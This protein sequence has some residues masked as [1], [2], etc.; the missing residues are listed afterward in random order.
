MSKVSV[1]MPAFNAGR[2]I[3]QAIESVLAQTYPHYEIVVVDDGSTDNTAEVTRPYLGQVRYIRQANSGPSRAR[4]RGIQE[5]S[6]SY[7]AFLDADDVWR[8]NKLE[9]Q[10][11]LME[12]HPEVVLSFTDLEEVR[13]GGIVTSSFLSVK[14]PFLAIARIEGTTAQIRQ[15]STYAALLQSC[16]INT[17]TV[18]LRREV[19]C[20]T[21]VFNEAMGHCEDWDL[22]LRIAERHT[23]GFL[24]EVLTTR[25]LHDQNLT[26]QASLRMAARVT[27]FERLLAQEKDVDRRHILIDRLAESTFK[28]GRLEFH[29]GRYAEAA[30]HFQRSRK[31]GTY[32]WK[33]YPFL[34]LSCLLRTGRSRE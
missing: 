25:R 33:L 23:I 20:E 34:L 17:A 5:A 16:F 1:V 4:N 24:N 19:L 6:G 9:R 15:E 32:H 18:V 21:G 26:Q 31:L 27:L 3:A 2:F 10:I 28:M 12:K 14:P 8:P 29:D 22:W 7:I 30:R 11:A 13:G